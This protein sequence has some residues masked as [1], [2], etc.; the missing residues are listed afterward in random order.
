MGGEGYSYGSFPGAATALPHQRVLRDEAELCGVKLW[1]IVFYFN[2]F[3][4]CVSFSIIVPSLA[5]YLE[6]MNA[7]LSFLPWVVSIYAVGELIGS[8]AFGRLYDLAGRHVPGGNGPKVALA[9]TIVVGMIGSAMYVA[10]EWYSSPWLVFFGRAVQGLWTGGKQAIEQAYV[11]CAVAPERQTEV[12]AVLGAFAVLGFITGPCF[13]AAF[14]AVDVSILGVR[15]DAYTGPG[16]FIL[17]MTALMLCGTLSLFNG[18]THAY[19][20]KVIREI[21]T[22]ADGKISEDDLAMAL[23]RNPRIPEIFGYRPKSYSRATNARTIGIFIC[24]WTHL[25]HF[26]SFA[27]QETVITPMAMRIYGWGQLGV[28]LLFVA[29]GVLSLIA[30]VVLKFMARKFSERYLLQVS[31]VVGLTGCLLLM[32]NITVG[33]LLYAG[34]EILS[35]WRFILGFALITVAFPFGRTVS[36]GLYTNVLGPG[37]NGIWMGVIFAIGAIPRILGPFSAMATLE[38]VHWRTW[39]EFASTGALF[40]LGIVAVWASYDLLITV[41]AVIKDVKCEEI[42]NESLENAKSHPYIS[43]LLRKVNDPEL[44]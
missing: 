20:R 21:G 35:L 11:G 32:D 2:I 37:D 5:P 6:R 40:V 4:S 13:G 33:S 16:I 43:E 41:K 39:L 44:R 31:L 29:A 10:A 3:F 36:L 17:L 28:N 42:K 38:L 14:T 19:R 8:I 18:R 27:V 30:S 26:Y 24:L 9:A 12:T 7:P 22:R 23:I 1:M 34:P 15:I 25:I